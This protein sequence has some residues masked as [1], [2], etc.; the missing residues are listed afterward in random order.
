MHGDSEIEP[1]RLREIIVSGAG[2]VPRFRIATSSGRV[3]I[4]V[5]L[6]D[7]V[8]ARNPRM[9]L[10]ADFIMVR[11]ASAYV[12]AT[13]IAESDAHVAFGISRDGSATELEATRRSPLSSGAPA[14]IEQEQIGDDLPSL[15]P[16]K[17]STVTPK[18]I[19]AVEALI[20][21]NRGMQL[22][23]D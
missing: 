3:T 4:F 7:D 9:Q 18:Q 10:M 23:R 16:A 17:A 15:L 22:D 11:M 2:L 6:P 19:A 1:A 14:W 5:Q 20:R 21:Y 13:E 12:F 8:L